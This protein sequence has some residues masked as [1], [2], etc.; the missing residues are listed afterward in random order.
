MNGIAATIGASGRQDMFYLN[1]DF[2]LKQRFWDGT[3]W[4]YD[5][6]N[7]GGIFT[8]VPVAVATMDKPPPI[9]K[10]TA[11]AQPASAA[12]I[13]PAT[14][15]N[16][17][18]MSEKFVPLPIPLV[19]RLD[20]FGLGLDYAMYHKTLWGQPADSPGP[21][22]RLGGIFTSTPAAIAL[23]GTIHVFGLGTDYSMYHRASNGNAWPTDWERLGGFFSSAAS[24]VS[25]G[26]GRLDVFAR[27]A[28]FTL[29]HRSFEG[30]T[31]SSDWQ[32][33]GGSLASPPIAVTWG[34]NRLDVFAVGHD[35]GRII[36]RWWDGSIWND[37]ETV[38][39]T[40]DLVFTSMPAAV[41]WGPN[42]LDV[43][44]TGCDGALYH[45]WSAEDAWSKPESLDGSISTTPTVLAP[46]IN[47]LDLIGPGS[48]GNLYHKHW[49]GSAWQPAG[50]EQLGDKTR[51]PSRYVFSVDHMVVDT[52]RS[53]NNDTD[54][55]QCSLAI[56]NWPTALPPKDWPLL[57]KTQR[58]GDLG[59]TAVK[60]GATN[61]MNFGPITVELCETAIFNYTFM[62]SAG[63]PSFVQSVLLQQGVKLADL[64]VQTAIKDIGTG[65]GITVV[66]VAGIAAPI[67]GSLLGILASWLV[68]ELNSIIEAK[69]DGVV[70][71]E[72]ILTMG[73]D[74]QGK[75]TH[76]PY[77]MT[78]VHNGTDTPHGCG[79]NS[80]YE[81]TWSIRMD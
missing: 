54:T 42:R 76:G 10:Q 16:T 71:A 55:G 5:W 58:Q 63:D 7:L 62:N 1:P 25:W 50:W 69:C 41:T 27:G 13:A 23:D 29:R 40:K 78:T 77:S 73:K 65:L 70:A 19:Q 59:G 61:L 9:N 4:T 66:D 34:P 17:S 33:L 43:F 35:D 49:D 57:T 15:G 32:N 14:T 36:H 74:L 28:D 56:G 22:D 47:H 2:A 60:E 30:N 72:Q 68:S 80:Q 8:S 39:G 46:A 3:R 21:W 18:G 52:A 48:D 79:S 53:F 24:V 31:W 64:G 44:A 6:I 11:A 75:T 45:V 67:I 38:A 81:V 12:P 51:L 20:V 37:W 26:S